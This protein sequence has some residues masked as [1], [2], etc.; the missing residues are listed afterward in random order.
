MSPPVT[1]PGTSPRQCGGS[2]TRDDEARPGITSDVPTAAIVAAIAPTVP[3]IAPPQAGK[4]R[5]L[6]IGLLCRRWKKCV[7]RLF[8]V[9]CGPMK[10]KRAPAAV[11]VVN[12]RIAS[13]RRHILV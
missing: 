8:V 12:K 6:Y 9:A 1:A 2:R 10:R 4:E 11:G 13:R 3:P 7:G 5:V